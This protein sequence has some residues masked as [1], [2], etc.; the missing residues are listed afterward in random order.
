MSNSIGPLLIFF[1]TWLIT[2][3]WGNFTQLYWGDSFIWMINAEIEWLSLS[4]AEENSVK[5]LWFTGS[6]FKI[7]L[8]L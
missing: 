6:C 8:N 7:I 5:I 2:P 4:S 3:A 1:Q